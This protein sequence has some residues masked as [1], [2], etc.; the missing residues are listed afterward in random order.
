GQ[1]H[2]VGRAERRG[3]RV[4]RRRW[5]VEAVAQPPAALALDP[6]LA[7]EQP[8]P[9]AQLV[10]VVVRPLRDLGLRVERH[11][12]LLHHISPPAIAS[13]VPVT[14]AASGE[15]RYT[16]AAATSSGRIRR[17]IGGPFSYAVRTSACARP[18]MA[19]TLSILSRNRS[20]SV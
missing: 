16:T 1:R 2:G 6:L 15:Q 5:D 17:P 18:V 13:V 12:A 8:Q 11:G 19:A 3:H 9:Q 4:E 20:V 7:G 10:L 14:A